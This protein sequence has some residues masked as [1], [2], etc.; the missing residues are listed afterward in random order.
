LREAKLFDTKLGGIDGAG[1]V[2]VYLFGLVV[3]KAVAQ[4]VAPAPASA[5]APASTQPKLDDEAAKSNERTE[6][7]KDD[8]E[9]PAT[10]TS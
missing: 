8:T 5:S 7:A 10:A 2:G 1:N 3:A 4:P 6:T 9:K